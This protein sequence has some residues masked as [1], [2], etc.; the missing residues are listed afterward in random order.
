M[1]SALSKLHI[2]CPAVLCL[3]AF[4]SL[5]SSTIQCMESFH[6]ELL[7]GLVYLIRPAFVVCYS[8]KGQGKVDKKQ[9]LEPGLCGYCGF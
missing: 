5:Y 9:K 3:G 2:V 8:G 1:R 7:L 4:F 6:S